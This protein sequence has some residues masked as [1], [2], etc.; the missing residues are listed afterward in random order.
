LS[1][2]SPQ[3]LG[4]LVFLCGLVFLA[5]YELSNSMQPSTGELVSAKREAYDK[6][7][8]GGL[9]PAERAGAKRGYAEGYK[10]GLAAGRIAGI[11]D[12]R[13]VASAPSSSGTGGGGD[14]H[15][16][17]M[18]LENRNYD[19]VVGSSQAAY[20]NSLLSEGA[21]ATRFYAITHPS[22]PNYIASVAGSTLGVS[23]DCEFCSIDGTS[24]VDQLEGA[25]L[26]WKA[27]ME[28]VPGPCYTG[29]DTG[30][31]ARKHNPF[32][33][34][35]NIAK[36]PKR[37]KLVQPLTSLQSD[38]ASNDLPAYSW[39]TPDLCNDGHDCSTATVDSFL[40]GIVPVIQEALGPHGYLVITW[41]EADDDNSGCCGTRGGRIPTVILGPDVKK[42]FQYGADATLYSLLATVEKSLGLEPLGA[43]AS[44]PPLDPLFERQPRIR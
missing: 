44:A 34:F 43:A 24:I 19:Q 3:Q 26:S 10:A 31:Y 4:L 5:A 15:V 8:L 16:V 20:F 17:V 22:E 13:L 27:Y 12:A 29:G 40:S 38:V 37:C 39:I 36:D 9:K 33:Q 32:I 42:G 2:P 1:R 14:S 35:N 7:F 30:N 41:D 6:A 11:R 28:G 23:D 18:M 25:G 21:S